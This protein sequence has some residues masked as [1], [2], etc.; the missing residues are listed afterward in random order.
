M[1]PRWLI[2]LAR[3]PPGP[4]TSTSLF[5]MS[6]Q[7]ASFGAQSWPTPSTPVRFLAG[8]DG[9][10]LTCTGNVLR[11][12]S[13]DFVVIHER[14]FPN[15][16]ACQ[17]PSGNG[18]WGSPQ[19]GISPSRRTVLVSSPL[20]KAY[21]DTLLDVETF[22]VVASWNEKVRIKSISD[23]WLLGL[24]GQRQDPC[25]RG[26]HEPWR[27]FQFTEEDKRMNDFRSSARF[28]NDST[29]VM[30]WNTIAAVTVDGVQLFQ[31]ELGKKR[32]VEG[33]VTSSGGERFAVIED[34]ERG[35]TSKPLDMYAFPSNDRGVVYSVPDRGT[36][37][38][39]KVKGTSPWPWWETHSN[40]LALSADGARLAVL[41]G[42]A[43]KVYRLP[44]NK[45]AH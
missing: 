11:L 28:V 19:W 23:D 15:N 32:S 25:I 4:R 36:V 9:K 16:H 37:Y 31:A 2:R 18:L 44:P 30:G 34:R 21:E 13:Q 38:S 20:G 22:A 35:L 45:P 29:L 6:R 41:D 43:L 7:A 12:F 8:R 17:G 14:N 1:I 40:R 5:W 33:T 10:F 24:C 26:I 27:A 3:W 42:A 39:V